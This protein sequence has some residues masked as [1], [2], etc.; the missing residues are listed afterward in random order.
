MRRM[1]PS[2]TL[3]Q[4]RSG[5]EYSPESGLFKW[6]T[7]QRAGKLAGVL[8]DP[9][10]YPRVQITLMGKAYLAHRL[11][12]FYMHGAWPA[13]RIDHINGNAADNR[14]CNLRIA[15]QAENCQ[16]QRRPHRDSSSGYLGVS[17]LKNGMYRATIMANGRRIQLA[18]VTCPKVASLAYLSAKRKLH[19][20]ADVVSSGEPR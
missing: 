14:M 15:S 8:R 3:E 1:A 17:K 16:N 20:G 4:V 9:A 5:L 10:V 13:G 12:W 6:R 18:E 2:V 11:A 7:G 19:P